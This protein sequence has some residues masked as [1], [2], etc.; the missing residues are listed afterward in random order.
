MQKIKKYIVKSLF[1]QE[2]ILKYEIDSFCKSALS[3]NIINHYSIVTAV[4]NM[5]SYLDKFFDSIINQ[6]LD[7]KK[8]IHIILIDDGSTDN[9]LQIIQKYKEKF[10]NNI[11]YMSCQNGGQAKARNLALKH[12]KSPWVTFIDADDTVNDIYF[13]EVHNLI[14]KDVSIESV[15]CNQVFYIPKNK[16]LKDH[17]LSYRFKNELKVVNPTHMQS[18]IQSTASSVF[19]KQELL[20]K[21][22][23]KFNEDIKPVFEDG[24]FINTLFIKE[25]TINI[26]FLNKPIYFY[27]KRDDESSTIDRSWQ[28]QSRYNESLK[29]ALLDLLKTDNKLYIQR[30]SL[31]QVYWYFKKIIHNK[32][33]VSFLDKEQI[34]NF[35]NL[36]KDIFSYIDSNTIETCGLG[37]MWHKYRIGFY[38]L[39]KGKILFK[40]VC[41]IDCYDHEKKEL[42][43]H[44]YYHSDDTAEFFLNNNKIDIDRYEIKEHMFLD[45][46]FVYEK[47]IYIKTEDK[48]AYLDARLCNVPTEISLDKKRF[49]N[50]IS[51]SEI[52]TKGCK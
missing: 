16:K 47:T 32:D 37:G 3:N 24:H 2:N 35:K 21:H 38:K 5:E 27:T 17:Y 48:W 29:F 45:E 14:D 8:H 52:I 22:D 20:K 42:K 40:Q 34:D 1:N 11:S 6:T 15:S 36:L 33:I 25:P 44:Y 9:S 30:Y 50:G 28:M 23:L 39:Y 18:F 26:A 49:K 12:V 7:F 41:Y 13:Q 46:I 10:D 19:F 43:L 31:Y 4:Y 51:I